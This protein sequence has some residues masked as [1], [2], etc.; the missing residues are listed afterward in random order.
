MCIHI[1]LALLRCLI[2]AFKI[3]KYPITCVVLCISY[4]C[5][6]HG[7]FYICCSETSQRQLVIA[8]GHIV[9]SYLLRPKCV[10]YQQTREKQRTL[11][12]QRTTKNTVQRQI[13][14]ITERKIPRE[15]THTHNIPNVFVLI[16]K[17]GYVYVFACFAV[18][19]VLFLCFCCCADLCKISENISHI[20][21]RF[22]VCVCVLVSE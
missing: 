13:Y 20:S 15:N 14:G 17:K 11:Y 3:G 7:L 1:H 2:L 6:L 9:W 21:I 19:I 22:L 10:R 4:S 18:K 5:V 8:G 16:S 12:L